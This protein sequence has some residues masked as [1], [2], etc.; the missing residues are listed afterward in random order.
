MQQS[1][2][3]ALWNPFGPSWLHMPAKACIALALLLGAVTTVPAQTRQAGSAP[4]GS[5][6]E[7]ETLFS[8]DFSQ[9]LSPSRWDYNR[10]ELGGSFYGRTQQRQ[11][12]PKV[13]N[14]VLLLQLDTFNLT[15]HAD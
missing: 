14:G 10:F 1:I 9:P 5:T 13:S 2:F 4:A 11:S 8:E 7:I 15:G 12:L 6:K 3:I